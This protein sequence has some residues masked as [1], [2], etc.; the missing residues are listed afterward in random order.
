M[1]NHCRVIVLSLP[2]PHRVEAGQEPS[3][4]EV[5]WRA[6]SRQGACFPEQG[7]LWGVRPP[8]L[9]HRVPV[10]LS[11]SSGVEEGRAFSNEPLVHMGPNKDL[12]QN[13]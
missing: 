10:C 2:H 9:G 8:G 4:S 13:N 5:R 12:S 1:E 11:V 7:Y 3:G 6:L